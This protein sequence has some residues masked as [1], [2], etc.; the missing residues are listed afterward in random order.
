MPACL[1]SG[2]DR[3]IF[4]SLGLRGLEQQIPQTTQLLK[5]H[6]AALTMHA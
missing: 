2:F 1:L 3:A 4:V 5:G 6:R